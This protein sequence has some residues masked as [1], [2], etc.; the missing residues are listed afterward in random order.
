MPSLRILITAGLAAC[1]MACASTDDLPA[2]TDDGLTR[3]PGSR[4][5]AA[6]MAPGADLGVYEVLYIR[7]VEVSFVANWLR[8]TNRD[9]RALSAQVSQ[10]D[11]DRIKAAVADSFQE[12][13]TKRLGLGVPLWGRR[14]SL[15]KV[16]VKDEVE[17][18]Q[19]R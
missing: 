6:Y 2:E 11:A 4:V 14:D 12:V 10:E 15:A 8:D 3:V 19:P 7:E 5:D 17:R 18:P 16:A 9:R 1:L 13:F